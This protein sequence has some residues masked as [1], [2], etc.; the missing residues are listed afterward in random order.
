MYLSVLYICI[1]VFECFCSVFITRIYLKNQLRCICSLL[2][3]MYQCIWVY[4]QLVINLYQ[5]IQVY[6]FI[7][8][9]LYQNL[10]VFS[11]DY[12][13]VSSV[14]IPLFFILYR[15]IQVYLQLVIN[16]INILKWIRSLLYI[17]ICI[18]VYTYLLLYIISMY[19]N[20]SIVYSSPNVFISKSYK[21]IQVNKVNNYKKFMY[22]CYTSN[23]H[24]YKKINEQVC[25]SISF[26]ITKKICEISKSYWL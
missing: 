14:F 25:R 18:R 1:N 12:T 23:I 21:C 20:I 19:F 8:I 5:C 22:L 10:S 3:M 16:W 7:V 6:L 11:T 2:C 15:C 17:C 24:W 4:L 9:L 26:F 13:F